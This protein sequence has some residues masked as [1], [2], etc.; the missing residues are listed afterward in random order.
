MCPICSKPVFDLSSAIG[1]DRET[2]LP[3]HFDCVYD[4]VKAA[5]NLGP[6]E[7]IVYLGAGAFA[8]V[9][10]KDAKEGAFIVKRRIQWEKEGEKRD[11]RRAIHS[12]F[13]GG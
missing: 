13:T 7:K 9:E 4:R 11:W 5:E 1:A 8:V 3:A 10:F 12:R 6:N 2:G